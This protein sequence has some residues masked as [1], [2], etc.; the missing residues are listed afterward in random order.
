MIRK[1][2]G[3]VISCI[4]YQESSVIVKIFTREL[5]FKSYIVNSVRKAGNK[6]KIAL[7]QPMTMLDLVV[8]EKEGA[9]LQRISEAKTNH[10]YQLIPFD[11]RKTS[12]ALF[13][14]EAISKSIYEN[15]QN[16]WLFDWIKKSLIHLDLPN[17]E[18]RHYPHAFLIQLAKFLGFGP[19]EVSIFLE[20]S[21][22]L[23]F[24]PE[25]IPVVSTYLHELM[26]NSFAC[27]A[28]VP[29]LIRRKLLDYL[30]D[31]FSEQLDHNQPWK[32]ITVIRQIM[33]E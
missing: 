8:Y 4:R 26:E 13:V 16:E 25:E 17:I 2:E 14:A 15:Y 30:L 24:S 29:H 23:P 1:T 3:I 32:S 7:Y 19:E 21:R 27:K 18:L 11:F 33:E 20:E 31:F 5:G 6:S 28:R 22:T 10:P 9:G 12:I